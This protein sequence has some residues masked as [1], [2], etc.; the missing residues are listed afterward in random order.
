MNMS[1]KLFFDN[2]LCSVDLQ[3]LLEK[4]KINVRQNRLAG[5]T[6]MEDGAMKAKGWGT[7]QEKMTIYDGVNLRATKWFDNCPVTLLSTFVAANHRSAKVGRK[8]RKR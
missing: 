3:V 8:K 4:D 2:W 5:C 6:F 7:H 1:L